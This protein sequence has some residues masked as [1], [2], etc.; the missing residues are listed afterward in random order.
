M[1][2]VEDGV[3]RLL[4]RVREELIHKSILEQDAEVTGIGRETATDSN[5][6][7]QGELW[8]TMLI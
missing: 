2:R 6:L 7:T 5:Q 1:K 3:E 4:G 8:E